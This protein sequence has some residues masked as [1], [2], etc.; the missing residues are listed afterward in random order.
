M[1]YLRC[2][3][4]TRSLQSA[5]ARAR[6]PGGASH[7]HDPLAVRREL[8]ARALVAEGWRSQ[9]GRLAQTRVSLLTRA[10]PQLGLRGLRRV[11]LDELAPSNAIVPP[12]F[13]RRSPCR[14]PMLV[15]RCHRCRVR[16]TNTHPRQDSGCP[17]ARATVPRCAPAPPPWCTPSR[18][19]GRR[20]WPSKRR[21]S[22][23]RCRRPRPRRNPDA[24][25]G[26][27]RA[28]RGRMWRR[29]GSA[30]SPLSA[31]HARPTGSSRPADRA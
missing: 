24:R 27:G 15:G 14:S 21:P 10:A 6:A 28:P 8:R 2:V 16:G 31:V 26:P 11:H 18:P 9:L 7:E 25:P 5:H 23:S 17:A 3:T 13:V 29:E 1:P 30:G 12:I 22:F 20:P 4:W 19:A